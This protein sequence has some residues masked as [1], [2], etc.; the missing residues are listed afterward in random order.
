MD[1]RA[2]ESRQ[3]I[4]LAAA[5][6]A[7]VACG[8]WQLP[9]AEERIEELACRFSADHGSLSMQHVRASVRASRHDEASLGLVESHVKASLPLERAIYAGVFGLCLPGE[10]NADQRILLQTISSFTPHGR[11]E[12][13]LIAVRF[14]RMPSGSLESTRRKEAFEELGLPVDTASELIASRFREL[15]KEFHP[16][17][18][19]GYSDA[20]KDLTTKKFIRIKDAYDLLMAGGIW[21][22]RPPL[23]AEV[24]EASAGLPV[25]CF[26]CETTATLA[27][28]QG[29]LESSRCPHCRSLLVYGRGIAERIIADAAPRERGRNSPPRNGPATAPPG[30]GF[31]GV[32]DSGG[33][34]G[35]SD[36]QVPG[37]VPSKGPATSPRPFALVGAGLLAMVGFLIANGVSSTSSVGTIGPAGGSPTGVIGPATPLPVGIPTQ[38]QMDRIRREEVRLRRDADSRRAS[39]SSLDESLRVARADM[40]WLQIEGTRLAEKRAESEATVENNATAL[41]SAQQNAGAFSQRYPDFES[42]AREQALKKKQA[43]IASQLQPF[44]QQQAQ[45]DNMR[46]QFG[47][48]VPSP[49][50]IDN[51][52]SRIVQQA[53]GPAAT[54]ER[55]SYRA[56]LAALEKEQ[57]RLTSRIAA[58]RKSISEAKTRIAAADER[59]PRLPGELAA[60][61]ASVAELAPKLESA[62]KAYDLAAGR[63]EEA[64]AALQGADDAVARYL[65]SQQPREPTR[66]SQQRVT[67]LKVFDSQ[68]SPAR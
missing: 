1:P 10:P 37:P 8:D 11:D 50:S 56:S 2:V 45:L 15:C 66:S 52:V 49:Q 64:S 13:N 17:K 12:L 18:V 19:R 46:Q 54:I 34:T 30:S 36:P 53:E 27:P 26:F 5:L 6:R 59:L 3:V 32:G 14:V 9:D 24:V 31:E 33:R 40:Q 25:G 35:P 47:G 41:K 38:E 20:I 68:D 39:L 58:I 23:E 22:C 29:V 4:A 57:A 44:W 7:S 55:Q 21:W 51:Q 61:Q 48:V 63:L 62:A 42:T 67:T 16:D 60:A 28:P 65:A 43:Y